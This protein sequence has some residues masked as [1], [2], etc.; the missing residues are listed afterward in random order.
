MYPSPSFYLLFYALRFIA[1]HGL[2]DCRGWLS[3]S[4]IHSTAVEE[5]IMGKLRPTEMIQ[6]CRPR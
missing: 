6:N 2:C 3:K 5:K 1:V 4:K